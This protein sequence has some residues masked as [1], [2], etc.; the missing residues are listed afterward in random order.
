MMYV[1]ARHAVV[2]LKSCEIKLVYLRILLIPANE[3][4]ATGVVYLT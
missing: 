2:Q 1:H 4:A 3:D